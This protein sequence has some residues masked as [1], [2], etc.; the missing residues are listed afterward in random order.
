MRILGRQPLYRGAEVFTDEFDHRFHI[1]PTGDVADEID[2]YRDTG[3]REHDADAQRQMG[4]KATLGLG[5]NASQHD[6]SVTERAKQHLM[7]QLIA[8][9]AGEIAQEP[10][11]HLAGGQGQGS[12][13]NR[14]YGASD[15]D[16]RAGN[17]AEQGAAAGRASVVKPILQRRECGGFGTVEMNSKESHE[18]T[19]KHHEH[20][21]QPE[22]LAQIGQKFL[23]TGQH[24]L[25]RIKEASLEEIAQGRCGS[26]KPLRPQ[27]ISYCWGI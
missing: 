10:W 15:A 25:S 8:T 26:A 21:H 12:N 2:E 17:G 22:R 4:D 16:C 7:C 6:Q 27:K 11:P 20:G 18:Q 14:K 13:G 3:E 1:D 5:P 9:V 24:Y 23:G 19:G